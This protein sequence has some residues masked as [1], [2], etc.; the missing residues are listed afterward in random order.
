VGLVFAYAFGVALIVGYIAF[1]VWAIK[2]VWSWSDE[3]QTHLVRVA[4]VSLTATLLFM[5]GVIGAGHGVGVGPA[6]LMFA[7]GTFGALTLKSKL[8]TLAGVLVG[9]AITFAITVVVTEP[10]K[11]G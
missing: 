8:M 7:S 4:L 2:K 6:W 11:S 5:P 10:K 9:W 1:G 3:I